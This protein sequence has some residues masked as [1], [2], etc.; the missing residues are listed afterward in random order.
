[1]TFMRF[2]SL[3]IKMAQNFQDP[4]E[5][6]KSICNPEAIDNSTQQ[7]SYCMKGSHFKKSKHDSINWKMCLLIPLGIGRCI[8]IL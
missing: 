8:C 2:M 4:V 1:M 5:V 7:S 3:I 6:S